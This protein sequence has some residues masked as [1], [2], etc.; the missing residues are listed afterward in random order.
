[1]KKVSMM[2]LATLLVLPLATGVCLAAS[3]LVN[4]TQGRSVP[5]TPTITGNPMC[6]VSLSRNVS[7]G[8]NASTNQQT[9]AIDS[10]HW[11]GDKRYGT[12]SDTTLLFWQST[13]TGTEAVLPTQAD[14]TYT[15]SSWSGM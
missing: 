11:A 5:I 15:D 4:H 13:A 9:Y 10:Q 8:Y 3:T 7:F 1:M 14:S 6:T 12:A 2:I